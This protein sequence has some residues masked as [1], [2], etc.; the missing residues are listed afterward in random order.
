M[1]QI[2]VRSSQ[3]VDVLTDL[4][5]RSRARGAAFSRSTVHGDWGLRFGSVPGFVVHVI[6]DGEIHLWLDDPDG[7]RRLHAGDIVLVRGE[8]THHLAHRPGA[9]CVRI[10][11]QVESRRVRFGDPD[12]GPA[13]DFFCGAYMFEG[14]LCDGLLDALPDTVHLRPCPGSA[15]RATMDLLAR[16]ILRDEPGQQTLLD[17]LLDVALVQV[18]RE[19][20]AA[21]EKN[22]PAWFRAE[23]DPQIGPALRALHADPARAW[24]VAELA[25]EAHLSRA[26]FARR[27][28][29]LLGAAPLAYLTDWR[30]ALACERLRDTEDGLAA[31]AAAVGYA[32]E[33][34]FAAAFKRRYGIAPG[35]WRTRARLRVAA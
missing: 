15:L 34:A 9:R 8:L 14:D 26:T 32:S 11:E 19:H 21:G 4:L 5:E 18:I 29:A 28:S 7:S 25:A 35:R 23:A 31:V 24:T 27:F 13:A 12:D 16:E 10:E 17:R 33:F 20:F 2:H 22:A 1:G 30:M 3:V 6:L